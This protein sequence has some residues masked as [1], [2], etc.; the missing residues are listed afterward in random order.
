MIPA[1]TNGCV[2]QVPSQPGGRGTRDCVARGLPPGT[3]VVVST[4]GA[5]GSYLI[6]WL[7]DVD[8][9]GNVPFPWSQ[10]QAGTTVFTVSAGGVTVRFETTF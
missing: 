10:P 3:T 2:P 6:T 9:N 1:G 7:P 4:S 5:G 8:P